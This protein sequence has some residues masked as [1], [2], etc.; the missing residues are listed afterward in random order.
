MSNRHVDGRRINAQLSKRDKWDSTGHRSS[1]EG[2]KPN[3]EFKTRPRK[4][5]EGSRP[6]HLSADRLITARMADETT[7]IQGYSVPVKANPGNFIDCTEASEV[8]ECIVGGGVMGDRLCHE[9]EA[10]FPEKLAEFFVRSFCPPDGTVLDPF[11][12][13]G[14]T[15][16]VA[17]QLGRHSIGVDIRESQ[18]DLSSR[19]CKLTQPT[20]S[21]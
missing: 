17:Q 12:G 14:T 21:D 19:R 15:L 9:N 7:Q 13:S 11:C 4:N 5:A 2:R 3:G 8:I 18:V 16:A 20:A 1:G 6:S 10:P